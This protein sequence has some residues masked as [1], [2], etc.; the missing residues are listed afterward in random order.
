V[1]SALIERERDS[2]VAGLSSSDDELR[3]LSVERALVLPVAEAI[4]HL[5]VSLGD[6]SWR[7]RKAGVERL[8]ASGERELV[9][10]RL[11]RALSDGDNPGRRNSAVEA[12]VL[13][14]DCV[15]EPL[16]AALDDDDVDVRKLVVDTIAGIGA[17]S[18][19]HAM[20]EVLGDTDANVRAAAADALGA[21]GGDEAMAGLRVCA[22]NELED[23]LVRLSSLRALASLEA[24]VSTDDLCGVLGDSTLAAAGYMLLGNSDAP[25]AIACLEKGL[26]AS[27]R[28]SREAAIGALLRVLSRQDGDELH[29]LTLRIR[30][31]A[32]SLP[33]LLE[34][35]ISRLPDADLATRLVLVQFLGLVGDPCCVVAILEAGRDEAICE[36]ALTTLS[37][38]GAVSEAAL[39]DAWDTLDAT[40][41]RDACRVLSGTRGGPGLSRLLQALDASD[42]EQRTAAAIS[43][44]DCHNVAALAPLVRRL[45]SAA[46]EDDAEAEEESLA[47]VDALV[48]LCTTTDDESASLIDELISLISGRVASA[49]ENGRLALARVLGRVG[50]NQDISLVGS[51]MK[52]PCAEVRSAA[53]EG[54]SR[55]SAENDDEPLRLALADE[56]HLV[57]I[58]AVSALV[59]SVREN[60]VDDLKRLACDDDWRVRAATLR[61][62]GNSQSVGLSEDETFS[63]IDEGLAD[64]GAVCVAAAEA[65]SSVGGERAASVAVSLLDRTEPEV[66]QTAIGCVGANGAL[67]ALLELLPLVSHESWAVR[68]QA[69]TVLGERSVTRALPNILRR[70]E[71]EQDA[72]VRD[73]ILRSLKRLE[74]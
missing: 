7:V 2:I 20:I 64:S 18:S 43:L 46:N 49:S 44:A 8:V 29:A 6:S 28:S 26:A 10:Q 24:K 50:R 11:I 53:V 69:I 40:M 9:A 48:S 39:D 12:L 30:E 67:D 37:Q 14:G 3:R 41:R 22:I 68:A 70:L 23:R 27:S 58:A 52:D 15:L 62:I 71:C 13:L 60:A 32:R 35:A 54:L 59:K 19:R 61:A 51:L 16:I 33:Q 47:V 38:L 5:I 34:N 57:R 36:V 63:M 1:S 56:S 66:V 74:A 21:I 45:E 73:A 42:V 55:L 31:T 25:Q 17:E 65:L 4:G 72:F